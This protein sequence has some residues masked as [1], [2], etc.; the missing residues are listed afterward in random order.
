VLDSDAET[1]RGYVLCNA[2]ERP[3]TLRKFR[4]LTFFIKKFMNEG[5]VELKLNNNAVKARITKIED[6]VSP[7]TGISK[8]ASSRMIPSGNA[9]KI[10]IELAEDYPI[11][12]FADYNE[13]GRFALYSGRKF[14]G[15]GI[16]I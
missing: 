2:E 4:S 6:I 15:I 16:V 9:A 13:L 7:T 11:E 14:C 5:E 3:H 10:E 8:T 1:R 12:R